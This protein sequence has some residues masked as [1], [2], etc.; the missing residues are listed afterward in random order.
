VDVTNTTIQVPTTISSTSIGE[1]PELTIGTSDVNYTVPSYSSD[2][3][4]CAGATINGV[5]FTADLDV[6][7]N[8]NI[9]NQD[10]VGT[11]SLPKYSDI[12]VV[13]SLDS[14]TVEV[15]ETVTATNSDLTIPT[16]SVGST[17]A[18][19]CCYCDCS[20]ED[21]SGGSG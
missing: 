13:G 18:E 6:P 19:G 1:I 5:G 10:V 3:H 7:V 9:G 20:E 17:T 14:T 16:I 15:V 2:T 11:V 12:Q 4:V 21:N 8:L